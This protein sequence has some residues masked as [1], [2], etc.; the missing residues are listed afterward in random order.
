MLLTVSVR[1]LSCSD[2]YS[3]T[4]FLGPPG[5]CMGMPVKTKLSLMLRARKSRIVSLMVLFCVITEE[6][7]LI[8]LTECRSDLFSVMCV[9]LFLT[10]FQCLEFPVQMCSI[11]PVV[12]IP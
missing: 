5:V 6:S 3:F 1:R 11:R 8:A 7:W 2:I 4:E 12:C 9:C 10:E